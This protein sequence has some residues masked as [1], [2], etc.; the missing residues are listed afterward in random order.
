MKGAVEFCLD[1][2]QLREDGKYYTAP[3]T[4]P[5]N[6]FADKEGRACG[7]SYMTTSDLAIIK[8]MFL[9]YAEAE[10]FLK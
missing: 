8:E 4:S 2:L 7:V 1:W 10:K 5:E 3:S 6:T 9:N